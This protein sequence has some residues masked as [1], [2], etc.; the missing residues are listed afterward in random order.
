MGHRPP[1]VEQPGRG[2]QEG[3]V[4]DA[5]DTPRRPRRL[6]DPTDQRGVDG[7]IRGPFPADHDQRVQPRRVERGERPGVDGDAGA[8]A[9]QPAGLGQDLQVVAAAE[10]VIGAAEHLGRAVQVQ[11]K[12]SVEQDEGDGTT[13]HGCLVVPSIVIVRLDPAIQRVSTDSGCP[14]QARA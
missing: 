8:G 5:A 3:A 14:G 10:Q 7:E 4:A 2:Q 6:P 9:D 1:A 11:P 13:G 12:G